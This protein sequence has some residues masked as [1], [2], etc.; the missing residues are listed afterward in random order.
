MPSNLAKSMFEISI[1]HFQN[2]IFFF[3]RDEN[4]DRRLVLQCI[5]VNTL[6]ANVIP[7]FSLDEPPSSDWKFNPIFSREF[8][9]NDRSFKTKEEFLS[10]QFIFC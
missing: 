4:N 2:F 7:Y 6:E 5:N 9:G 8:G 10:N 3:K 1:L